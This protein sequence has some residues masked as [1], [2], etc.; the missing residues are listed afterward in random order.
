MSLKSDPVAFLDVMA[1]R[2]RID[3]TMPSEALKAIAG[4]SL[5]AHGI[6]LSELAVKLAAMGAVDL[7][8]ARSLSASGD[9]GDVRVFVPP[10]GDPW[11]SALAVCTGDDLFVA[12]IEMSGKP[13]P[14]LDDFIANHFGRTLRDRSDRRPDPQNVYRVDVYRLR[15]GGDLGKLFS[16]VVA[17]KWRSDK[18]FG[19]SFSFEAHEKPGLWRAGNVD[20]SAAG[21]DHWVDAFAALRSVLEVVGDRSRIANDAEVFGSRI[22]SSY[23]EAA[24]DLAHFDAA[25][26]YGN[27]FAR[28]DSYLPAVNC[29]KGMTDLAAM[30]AGLDMRATVDMLFRIHETCVRF[31]HVSEDKEFDFNDLDDFVHA[32]QNGKALQ[33]SLRDQ[34]RRH[35]VEFQSGEG[36]VNVEV[37]SA[38]VDA[39]AGSE[40]ALAHIAVR[41]DDRNV[42]PEVVRGPG[43]VGDDIRAWNSFVSCVESADCCLDEE[44]NR[45]SPSP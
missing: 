16:E 42:K 7:N 25:A 44:Y 45:S 5:E 30:Q 23:R 27:H 8:S 21:V 24:P 39:P 12:C 36:G 35:R 18:L 17:E 34:N 1:P 32:D 9:R 11:V 38:P 2:G 20:L 43:I 15:A 14:K 28:Q 41:T 22:Y 40:T 6:H 29:V 26:D 10:T 4:R 33:I 3:H 13:N 37:F 31:D 19:C